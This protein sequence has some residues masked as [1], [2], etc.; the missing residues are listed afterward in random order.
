M[1]SDLATYR[2]ENPVLIFTLAQKPNLNFTLDTTNL[3]FC[4]LVIY[5]TRTHH[6]HLKSY[7]EIIFKFP[8]NFRT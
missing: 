5:K 3:A 4:A 1:K 7:H 6:I 2:A 8:T